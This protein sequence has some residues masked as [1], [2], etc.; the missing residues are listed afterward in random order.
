MEKGSIKI[1]YEDGKTPSLEVELANN[2]LWLTK[3][4]MAR[5]LNCFV[6]SI[7]A[8][9]HSIFKSHLLWENDCT[10]CNKYIDRGIEKQCMYY[11]LETLIFVSYRIN[12]LE[13]NIFRQ[14]INAALRERL[15]R[16]KTPKKSTKLVWFF[17]AEKNCM[18]N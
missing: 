4:E 7:D 9:L 17:Q 2:D 12:T 5:L 13:A 8:N 18:W 16:N 15:L 6:Q 14:F 3:Y 11:N 10:Y 1:I